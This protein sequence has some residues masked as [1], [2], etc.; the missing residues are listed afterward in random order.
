MPTRQQIIGE[1]NDEIQTAV[2]AFH[3]AIPD[4]EKSLVRKINLIIKDLD[5]SPDGTIK[6]TVANMKKMRTIEREMA[7]AF[8]SQKYLKSVDKFTKSYDTT[9]DLESKY[10][11]KVLTDYAEPSIINEIQSQAVAEVATQLTGSN[12]V[13]NVITPV[14]TLVRQG[15][16]SGMEW[17]DLRASINTFLTGADGGTG[18]LSRYTTTITN[19]S[20]NTFSRTYENTI[21]NREGIEWFE[22]VG[23]EMTNTRDF[24]STLDA[25]RWFHESEIAGFLKG[26]IGE[27][28]VPLYR[29]TGKPYGMKSSTTEQNFVQLAGGWNCGHHAYPVPTPLVPKSVREKFAKGQK[30]AGVVVNDLDKYTEKLD[31]SKILYRGDVYD[32]G[33][34]FTKNVDYIDFNGNEKNKGYNFFSTDKEIAKSY[35]ID[36]DRNIK[37]PEGVKIAPNMT[38]VNFKN[39]KVLDMASQSKTGNWKINETYDFL[40]EINGKPLTFDEVGKLYGFATKE[41]IP[42]KKMWELTQIE[43]REIFDAMTKKT[44]ATN[45]TWSPTHLSNFENG[46]HFKKF[47][48]SKGFDGYKFVDFGGVGG[49]DYAIFNDITPNVVSKEFL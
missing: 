1:I 17:D 39:I 30:G 28:T 21:A 35:A 27:R 37:I 19:D 8:E 6:T 36:I 10:F 34:K 12:I 45:W 13:A 2:D 23:R 40:S 49:V 46:I 32:K 4:L 29:K 11:N 15:I 26:R 42:N 7:T 31:D 14:N 47:L 3:D 44:S 5:L 43:Q 9:R 38:D 48:K 41:Q 25:K 33:K 22:Y 20:L 18:A 16:E 24:C